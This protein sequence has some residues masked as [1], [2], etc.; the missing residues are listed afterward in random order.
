MASYSFGQDLTLPYDK[1]NLIIILYVVVRNTNVVWRAGW[2][3]GE[4]KFLG[5]G[6]LGLS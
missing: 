4:G 6:I 1:T 5:E 3:M 2:D